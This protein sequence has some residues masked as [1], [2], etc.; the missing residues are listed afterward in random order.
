MRCMAICS[1]C[2]GSSTDLY[3]EIEQLCDHGHCCSE[4][5]ERSKKQKADKAAQKA[6]QKAAAP[7][8]AKNVP[9]GAGKGG[10]KSTGR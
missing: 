5:K 7:K 6:A 9:R 4:I 8:A 2:R 10:A 1:V 3:M